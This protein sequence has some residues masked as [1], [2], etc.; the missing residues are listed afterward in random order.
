[1]SYHISKKLFWK[2]VIVL[3]ITGLLA[4][5]IVEYLKPQKVRSARV[6]TGTVKAYVKERAKTTLPY[7]LYITMPQQGRI[8]PIYL[9]E[10]DKVM[11]GDVLA[12][13]ERD[14]LDDA[15]EEA[16]QLVIAMKNTVDT[17]LAQVEA[18]KAREKFAAWLWDVKKKLYEA[19]AVSKLREQ[20]AQL[21]YLESVIKAEESRSWLYSMDAFMAISNLLPIYIHRQLKRTE[22]KSPINGVV[23]KRHVWNEQVLQAGASIMD[24]GTLEDMQVTAE[25]LTEETVSIRSGDHVEIF[26]ESIGDKSIQGKVN[27]VEPQAFT[28]RSSLGVEEQRVEVIIDFKDPEDKKRLG[29][30]YRVHVKICTDQIENTLFVP[31]NVL[32]KNSKGEWNALV[33]KD[34]KALLKKVTTGIYNENQTEVLSGLSNGEEVIVAPPSTLKPGTRVTGTAEL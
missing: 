25:I 12:K 26:G 15:M 31:D 5:S 30:G 24:V 21:Q 4:T 28:K 7:T 20:E 1:M 19:K 22:I 16:N 13:L 8:L 10:G 14:D 32:F 6:K 2:I 17:S 18:A 9:K 3:L 27:R 34:G 33:I 29:L 11:K 23:L